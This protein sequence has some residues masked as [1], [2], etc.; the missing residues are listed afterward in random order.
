MLNVVVEELILFNILCNKC[1]ADILSWKD[2]G[3]EI[4][5]STF[6][7]SGECLTWTV[8]QRV[9]IAFIMVYLATVC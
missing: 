1:R 4:R 6:I 2:A 8:A 7:S 3:G 5:R 9:G